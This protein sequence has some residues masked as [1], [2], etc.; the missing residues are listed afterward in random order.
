MKLFQNLKQL[1]QSYCYWLA[2]IAA[3]L[4][5]LGVALYF[6]HVKEEMPC[7]VCIQI[8]L[9]ISLLVLVAVA[10]WVIRKKP[11]L[12]TTTQFFV[13]LIAIGLTERSYLLLG[14]ER[15]FIFADCGFTLGLPTWFAIEEW[16][17]QLYRI[18]TSCGYTPELLFSITMAEALMGLSVLLLLFSLAIV[19]ARFIAK[20]PS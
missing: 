11:F 14:T 16:F 18:E 4:L 6:Q 17:P 7:V 3:G 19:S 12:N 5:L 1:S 9:W 20:K 15:G 13:L 8:R 10:G 2:Y